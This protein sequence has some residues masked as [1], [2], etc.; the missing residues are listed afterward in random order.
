MGVSKLAHR[1]MGAS[2]LSKQCSDIHALISPPKPPNMESSCRI[3]T[4]PVTD[5]A[6]AVVRM[7]T[8]H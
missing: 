6:T 2:K 3:K 5:T 1:K 7:L 4:F 8:Q